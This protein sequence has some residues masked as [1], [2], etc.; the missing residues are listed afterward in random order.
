LSTKQNAPLTIIVAGL[1]KGG[2][3]RAAAYPAEMT[4]TAV[5][6][7]ADWS[8]KIGRAES[9]DAL[10]LAK[11]L[12]H[13]SLFPSHKFEP[14]SIK[15]ETYNSLIKN[16]QC[17]EPLAITYKDPWQMIE[18]GGSVLCEEEEGEGF[19]LC[20]VVGMSSDRKQLTC[21]WVGYP[22]LPHFKIKRSLVGLISVIK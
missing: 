13:G 5:K 11:D 12:P 20:K 14:P 18:V 6:A 3:P 2:A 7:A 9:E 22:K 17:N 16:I 10:K 8:L 1:D 19:Y 21:A 15:R 4:E